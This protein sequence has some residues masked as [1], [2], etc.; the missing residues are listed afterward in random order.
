MGNIERRVER[1][2]DRLMPNEIKGPYPPK[3]VNEEWKVEF[4]RMIEGLYQKHRWPNEP[5][6][7]KN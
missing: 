6:R 3:T 4:R 7:A 2:E 1:L 5:T